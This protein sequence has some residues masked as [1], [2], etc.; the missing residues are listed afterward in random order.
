MCMELSNGF[1]FFRTEYLKVTLE[2]LISLDRPNSS[3]QQAGFFKSM[4]VEVAIFLMKI[5]IFFM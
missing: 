2:L 4:K 5:A 3:F 1:L